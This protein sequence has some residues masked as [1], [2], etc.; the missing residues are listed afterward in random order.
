V[1][2]LGRFELIPETWHQPLMQRMVLLKD[3]PP[4]VRAFYDYI[5][6]PASQAIMVRYGF[7]MPRR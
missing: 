6:S 5:G 2:Q 3:A 4:S 1:A 7:A